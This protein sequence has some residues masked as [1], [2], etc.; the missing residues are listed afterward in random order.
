VA[1]DVNNLGLVLH[2]MGNFD[3]ARECFER[4]LKIF[5]KSLDEDH[6]STVMVRK[7]LESLRL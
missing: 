5:R 2:A 7:N 1:R 3:G 4:S 6:P